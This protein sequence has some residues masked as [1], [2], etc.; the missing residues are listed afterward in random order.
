MGR[1]NKI[2][3]NVET[4]SPN[5][6]DN[7]E[8]DDFQNEEETFMK[9][10]DIRTDIIWNTRNKILEYTEKY[11]YQLCEYLTFDLFDNYI[12]FLQEKN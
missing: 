3:K 9:N 11:S 6:E 8:N 5:I 2:T 4:V 12:T 10:D 7:D 1:K